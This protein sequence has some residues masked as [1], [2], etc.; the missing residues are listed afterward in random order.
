MRYNF[1]QVEGSPYISFIA[2]GDRHWS[3]L[4]PSG[5]N[6][7]RIYDGLRK[8]IF[9]EILFGVFAVFGLSINSSLNAYIPLLVISL[10]IWRLWWQA[11]A[12]QVSCV[13]GVQIPC[14]N[15]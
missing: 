14:N 10:L 15:H 6:L 13:Y 11:N 12:S 9:M 3:A 2:Y 4:L 8:D 7:K 1:V 5:R